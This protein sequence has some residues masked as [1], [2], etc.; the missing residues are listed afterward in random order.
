MKETRAPGSYAYIQTGGVPRVG[1]ADG[2]T[3]RGA[4][5]I[6]DCLQDRYS[7][8]YGSNAGVVRTS[9]GSGNEVPAASQCKTTRNQQKVIGGVLTAG[10]FAVAGA[11]GAG[12]LFWGGVAAGVTGN[13]EYRD[14]LDRAGV[15]R[16]GSEKQ[17]HGHFVCSR[18]SKGMYGGSGYC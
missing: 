11:T 9:S 1:A 8:Q 10:V 14:C 18:S 4:H 15:T 17:E 16:R 2:G 7:V 5:D 12:A 3:E 13:R 6:N